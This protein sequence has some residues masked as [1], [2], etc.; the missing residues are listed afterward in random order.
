[1][2]NLDVSL[3]LKAVALLKIN[4]VDLAEAVLRQMKQIDEDNCLTQLVH[5]WVHVSLLDPSIF[6]FQLYQS[7]T[8]TS[9]DELIT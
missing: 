1:L 6:S 3:A 2:Y 4:R 8:A 5:S 7:G 9:I